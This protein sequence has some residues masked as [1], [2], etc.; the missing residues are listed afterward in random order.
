MCRALLLSVCEQKV[1]KESLDAAQREDF[2]LRQ[3]FC[4][5][6]SLRGPIQELLASAVRL[7]AAFDLLPPLYPLSRC[8]GGVWRDFS[9]QEHQRLGTVGRRRAGGEQKETRPRKGETVP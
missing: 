4:S 6:L 1:T 2:G 9:P 3:I 7:I 5:P 8:C